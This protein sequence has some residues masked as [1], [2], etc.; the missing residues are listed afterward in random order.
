VK[1]IAD[2]C[3]SLLKGHVTED[4]DEKYGTIKGKLRL[5][6]AILDHGWVQPSQTWKYQSPGIALS[7][8]SAAFVVTGARGLSYAHRNLFQRRPH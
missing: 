1:Q 3:A 6:A 2:Y 7:N 4:A 5:V 8:A